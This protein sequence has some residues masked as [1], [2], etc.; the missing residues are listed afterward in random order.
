MKRLL[1]FL[2]VFFALFSFSAYAEE[3]PSSPPSNGVYDPHGYL[4]QDVVNEIGDLNKQWANTT[5]KPQIAV[6]VID[7]LDSSIEEVSN[8]VARDWKVG[9]SETNNGILLVIAVKDRKIRTETSNNLSTLITDSQARVLNDAVKTDFRRGAYSAGVTSYLSKLKGTIAP[10]LADSNINI[11]GGS[12]KV[13]LEKKDLK[14]DVKEFFSSRLPMI[15]MLLIALL[16]PIFLFA[17]VIEQ[18]RRREFIRSLVDTNRD[19]YDKSRKY[20][21]DFDDYYERPTMKVHKN[22]HKSYNNKKNQSSSSGSGYDSPYV[23]TPFYSGDSGGSSYSSSDSSSSWS[24]GD[25]WSGGGFDGGGSSGD[26]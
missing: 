24:G 12:K 16:L 13:D 17:F 1:L 14:G 19:S 23:S 6:A 20:D 21:D 18:I 3:I 4:N 2:S 5:L 11:D 7:H 25:S 15:S 10:Y 26:W 22:G 9:F 8:R